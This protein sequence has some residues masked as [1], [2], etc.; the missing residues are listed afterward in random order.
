MT[1]L[2]NSKKYDEENNKKHKTSLLRIDANLFEIPEVVLK[3]K[4]GRKAKKGAKIK[5]F[6]DMI[7]DSTTNWMEETI[8]WWC[9]S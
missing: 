1:L 9:S 2:C 7:K 6:F 3:G 4:R 5:S 8:I